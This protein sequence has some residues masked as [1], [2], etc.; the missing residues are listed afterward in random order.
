MDL[1]KIVFFFAFL[2]FVQQ[3]AAQAVQDTQD[4][5]YVVHADLFR[6]ERFDNKE[7][8]YL[9]QN[10]I[11]KHKKVFLLCD[12]AV[13]EGKKVRSIGHVRIVESDS[14]Q[15]FGDTLHY[16]GELQTA[17]FIGDVILKHKEKTL[18]TKKLNYDLKNRIASYY[19]SAQLFAQGVNLK[20][21]RGYYFAKQEQ[22][23]FKDS[24]IVVLDRGMTLFADSL[25]YEAKQERVRFTGPTLIQENDLEIYTEKGYHDISTQQS[26]F[27]DFPRYRRGTSLAEAEHIYYNAQ[28]GAISLKTN[29]WIRDS[30]KEA[31]GDSIYFNEKT[32]WVYIFKNAEYKEGDRIL[33]GD[34]IKFNRSTQALEVSGRS[35]VTEGSRTIQGDQLIYS[36]VSDQGRA[37][38]QVIVS[39]TT[40][41]YSVYC[42]T[43]DY[44][45]KEQKFH[46]RGKRP[47]ISTRL[48]NDTLFLASD[49][50]Y[51]EQMIVATDTFQILRAFRNVKIWSKRIQGVCDSLTYHGR[52][53][54]FN[55][56]GKPVLWSDTTQFSGDTIDLFMAQKS[57]DQIEMFPNGFIIN[58][59]AESI[60]N[61]IKGRTIIADFLEKKLHKVFIKGNSESVY[62]IQDDS[63][64]F[65]GAN[66]IQ[67]SSMTMHF[68]SVEQVNNIDFFTKPEGKMMPISDGKLK[69][70]DGYFP[71]HAERPKTFYDLIR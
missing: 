60:E 35:E 24:V 19:S 54:L 33:K 65:I 6:F 36:G 8:Q 18:F 9:S 48:D 14:L 23:F 71:R 40:S 69:I 49:S 21:K 67:C 34:V 2:C 39:D 29:A 66:Y 64:A 5:V 70:L 16:D 7:F 20:S 62:F 43:L 4:R 42:D 17:D 30:L 13:I 28:E 25:V 63:K 61:Q 53:S 12:S 68:D 47:Y 26:Y 59:S 22:A 56:V 31:R 58:Q 37:I 32:N 52:D 10:V 50:L 55:L 45:K 1:R 15:I 27:G 11:V 38:G 3:A 44:N 51:S 46:A 57:I 41:G